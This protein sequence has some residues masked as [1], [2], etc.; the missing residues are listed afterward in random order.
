[1]KPINVLITAAG[2]ATAITS[3]RALRSAS[4]YSFRITS[5]D[6][7][8]YSP[9]FYF[10]D[11]HY[12]IPSATSS[13]YIEALLDI[14]KTQRIT[15]LIPIHSTEIPLVAKNINQFHKLGVKTILPSLNTLS[16]LENKWEIFN[17]CKEIALPTPE[18]WLFNKLSI[19]DIREIG[20]PLYLKPIIG[21]GGKGNL[22]VEDEDDLKYYIRKIKGDYL[23]QKLV[24]HKEITVDGIADK[25]S[26]TIR[27]LPRIRIKIRD[28]K[29]VVTKSI[30]HQYAEQLANKL[31]KASNIVGPFNIQFFDDGK[32]LY[33]FDVNTRF[34]A[35][36][37]PLTLASGINIPLMT[38]ELALDLDLSVPN[39][40]KYGQTMIRY[41]TEIFTW[42]FK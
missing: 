8:E 14:C 25:V 38:I 40:I 2:G 17:L 13:N 11:H 39:E 33:L 5:V 15:I 32:E 24:N 20:Y 6:S 34:A 22:V 12:V 42:D 27:M 3:I 16:L 21:S 9:G 18:T 36:G 26:N 1:M 23:A 37:L 19:S 28:G 41:Y 10:S 30:S 7:Y 31:V 29:A 35:G 4:K